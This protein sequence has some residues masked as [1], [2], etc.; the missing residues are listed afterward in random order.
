[1]LKDIKKDDLMKAEIV[2]G[3]SATIGAVLGIKYDVQSF[4]S[5]PYIGN[6]TDIVAGVT[7]LGAMVVLHKHIKKAPSF[8]KYAAVG[9]AGAN[10]FKGALNLAGIQV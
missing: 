7:I 4:Y 2:N 1:M 5:I 6:Y 8:V 9:Y 3:G 10:L